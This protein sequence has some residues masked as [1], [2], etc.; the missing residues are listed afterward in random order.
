MPDQD[1]DD[2]TLLRLVAEGDRAAFLQLFDRHA[3]SLLRFGVAFC[4]DEAAAEDALQEAWMAV[5]KGAAGFRGEVPARAWLFAIARN[6]LR[7]QK[8]KR[9]GEPDE[10]SSLEE[11]GERAGFG[12]EAASRGL[13]ESVEDREQVTKAL[14]AL[15]EDE[16]ELLWLVDVE[17]LSLDE[18][19][20]SFGLT[21]AATKSRLHR[22]RLRLMAHLRDNEVRH[23][24]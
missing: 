23:A 13:A 5:L 18:A 2:V 10:Q 12:D 9:A 7:R 11:L 1:R 16:R 21:L 24:T 8:R 3:A 19:A 6:A 22:A 15:C 20:A 17:G 4:R 14:E